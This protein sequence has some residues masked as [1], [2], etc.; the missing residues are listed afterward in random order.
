MKNFLKELIPYVII[1]LVVVLIRTFVV[2]PIRVDGPSMNPTLKN[3]NIMILNKLAKIDRFDIVVISS[4]KTH[5]TLIKRVIAMPGETIEVRDGKIYI[6]DKKIKDKYGSGVTKD[7]G[8]IRVPKD[9]YFVMGDNRP[10]SA[11]SRVF[12]TFNKKEIKGTTRFILFPFKSFG[13]VK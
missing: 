3:G 2:T 10:V 6:N 7:F 1:I 11:D 4:S 9:S 5:D 13:F 8:K 12:G